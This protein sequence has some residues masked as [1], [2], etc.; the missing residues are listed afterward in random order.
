ML[1]KKVEKQSSHDGS[2]TLCPLQDTQNC[3]S[4][5]SWDAHAVTDLGSQVETSNIL[6]EEL[7]PQAGSPISRYQKPP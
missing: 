2:P 3:D 1:E 5:R 6:Y 7:F 4:I